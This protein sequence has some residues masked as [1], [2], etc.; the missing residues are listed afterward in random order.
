MG[1]LQDLGTGAT[2]G[3]ILSRSWR[4]AVDN[5]ASFYYLAWGDIYG[6]ALQEV[7]TIMKLMNKQEDTQ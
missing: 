7:E 6:Y 4:S 1:P 5:S 3:R 2:T